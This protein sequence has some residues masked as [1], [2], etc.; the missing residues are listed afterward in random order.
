MNTLAIGCDDSSIKLYDLRAIGKIGKY[1]EEQGYESVQSLAF[2]NSGRL[3]FSSYNNNK[4][5]VWDVLQERKIAQLEGMHKEAVKSVALSS[6][7]ATLVSAG[8]DGI[9]TLWQ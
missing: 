7:G 1:K 2:S 8:K 4:V 5:K 9:I 3:L 6:D